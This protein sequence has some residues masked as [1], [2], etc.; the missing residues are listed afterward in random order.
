MLPYSNGT[1]KHLLSNPLVRN[2]RYLANTEKPRDNM[3]REE[4]KFQEK[5]YMTGT[6]AEWGVIREGLSYSIKKSK[7]VNTETGGHTWKRGLILICRWV[8][9]K[10][11]ERSQ[12]VPQNNGVGFMFSQ[13]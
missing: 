5:E 9:C 7:V 13:M 3:N 2:R 10:V 8:R 6:A 11:K 1:N 4:S 12:D